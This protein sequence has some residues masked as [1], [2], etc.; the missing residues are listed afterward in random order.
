[1]KTV[2]VVGS[3]DFTVGFALAGVR[4]R[5]IAHTPDE[6]EA[7]IQHQLDAKEAGILIID[8]GDAERV[9]ASLRRRIASSLD[10]VVVVL[11]GS[12]GGDLREKVRRAIGIDLYKE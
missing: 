3:D 1:M 10:P 4:N 7:G 12:G 6:L 5:T 2:A 11:G 8:A 9:S